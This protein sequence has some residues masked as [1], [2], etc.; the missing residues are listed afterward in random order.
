VTS[1]RVLA[2]SRVLA[3]A[4]A[5]LF[6]LAALVLTPAPV[7]AAGNLAA[8]VDGS[9]TD[10]AGE[11]VFEGTLTLSG[12]ERRGDRLVAL[13]TLDG[14]FADATG[15]QLGD[16]DGR[17]LVLAVDAASLAASC[18][19]CTLKLRLEDVEGAGVRAHLQPVEVEI[20][21]GAAPDHRLEAPLCE[22]AKLVGPS[23]DL[24]AVAQGLDRVLAALE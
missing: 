24:G 17:A 12:F 13:G 22:L 23:A 16:L 3:S 21:A 14:T 18:E 11:G 19:R 9:F 6:A 2:S 20:G 4:C 15:K 10:A 5:S 7:R 1:H 8:R